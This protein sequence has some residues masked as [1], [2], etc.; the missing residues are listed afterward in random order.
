MS[1]MVIDI[2]GLPDDARHELIDFYEFLQNKYQKKERK[3]VDFTKLVPRELK[4]FKMPK[5]NELY[6]RESLL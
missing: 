2:G 3:K 6:D 5:R 4:P 1:K